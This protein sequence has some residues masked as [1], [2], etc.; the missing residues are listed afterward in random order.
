MWRFILIILASF[1]FF[2]PVSSQ[3]KPVDK[4]TDKDLSKMVLR[5]NTRDKIMVC[6]NNRHQRMF[7][8]RRHEMIRRNQM[9]MQRRMQMNHQRRMMRQQRI[10]QQR[11][12]QQ[13]V[14][15]QM[16]RQGAGQGR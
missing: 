2:S 1:W 9:Q 11:L 13:R 6:R 3:E 5:V 7:Q 12:Q 14:H 15:R 8:H 10:R 4:G 16:S